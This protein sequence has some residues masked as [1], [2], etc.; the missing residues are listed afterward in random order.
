VANDTCGQCRFFETE[1]CDLRPRKPTQEACDEF[2]RK[3]KDKAKKQTRKPQYKDSGLA[4]EGYFEAIY[5]NGNPTFLIKH[6]EGF[7]ISETVA[8]N[9]ETFQPKG[10]KRTPY[11]PYGYSRGK[12]PNREALFWK[13]R[14]E[15]HRFIDV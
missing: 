10:V 13:I 6:S 5:H 2:Y 15:F 7:T 1:A 8:C 14:E 12:V 11:T 3:R 4:A 9:R